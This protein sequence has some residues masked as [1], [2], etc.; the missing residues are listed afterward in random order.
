MGPLFF[1]FFFLDTGSS[2]LLREVTAMHLIRLECPVDPCTCM[3]LVT[4]HVAFSSPE[5]ALPWVFSCHSALMFC[6]GTSTQLFFNCV[7]SQKLFCLGWPR[8]TILLISTSH[9]AWDDRGVPPQPV[10]SWNGGLTYCLLELAS[11]CN[12]HDLSLPRR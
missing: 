5:S 2:L 1:F 4:C 3:G 11:N 12:P 8:T 10:I 7:G 9:V 6:P